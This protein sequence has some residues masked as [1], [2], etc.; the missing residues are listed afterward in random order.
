[1]SHKPGIRCSGL[2]VNLCCG[3]TPGLIALSS[4]GFQ[5]DDKV[6]A[7]KASQVLVPIMASEPS[8]L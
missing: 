2:R 7:L 5:D 8:S 1:M 6:E 4:R 3:K